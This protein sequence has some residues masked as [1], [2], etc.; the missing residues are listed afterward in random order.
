MKPIVLGAIALV[1]LGT[2]LHGAHVG[3]VKAPH[4]TGHELSEA[5]DKEPVGFVAKLVDLRVSQSGKRLLVLDLD[6][7]YQV[8]ALLSSDVP[9]LELVTGH[10][11]AVDAIASRPG[12]VLVSKADGV[13]AVVTATPVGEAEADVD[14]DYAYVLTAAGTVRVPARG[15][16][17]GFQHVTLVAVNGHVHAQGH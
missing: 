16:G 7:G 13:K 9:A 4:V 8:T 6:D 1:C 17:D 5:K 12:M 11:Y 3:E 15:L 2:A 10:R 14:C